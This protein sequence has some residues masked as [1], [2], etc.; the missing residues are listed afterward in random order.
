[1]RDW[2]LFEMSWSETPILAILI[3]KNDDN[4][5]KLFDLT[6]N[7]VR[8]WGIIPS[9]MTRCEALFQVQELI[10][11]I[12]KVETCFQVVIDGV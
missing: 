9:L 12:P 2:T 5:G 8:L 7:M 3:R 6:G 10:I 11:T 4:L 1:M